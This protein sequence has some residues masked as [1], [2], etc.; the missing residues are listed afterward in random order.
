[1]AETKPLE[2]RESGGQF[3]ARIIRKHNHCLPYDE[4]T[5]K[6]FILVDGYLDIDQIAAEFREAAE[7]E[8]LERAAQIVENEPLGY[9]TEQEHAKLENFADRVIAKLRRDLGKG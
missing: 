4:E 6:S 8:T 1:M 9:I 5:E 2:S 3:L 7:R